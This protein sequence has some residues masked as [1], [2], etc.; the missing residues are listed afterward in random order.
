MTFNRGHNLVRGT[1]GTLLVLATA[2]LAGCNSVN[3]FNRG[4]NE[5]L[6]PVQGNVIATSSNRDLAERIGAPSAT[7][8]AGAVVAGENETVD[9]AA[10]LAE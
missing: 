8:Q 5:P 3:P 7:S 6:P 1:L 9:D 4:S 10:T 2:G